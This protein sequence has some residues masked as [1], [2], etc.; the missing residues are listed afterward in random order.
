[1]GY[2]YAS[3]S[4]DYIDRSDGCMWDVTWGDSGVWS[5]YD[6]KYDFESARISDTLL[7][8]LGV[9]HE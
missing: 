1:M 7:S 8:L 4:A 3:V 9:P 5:N 2:R 6:I